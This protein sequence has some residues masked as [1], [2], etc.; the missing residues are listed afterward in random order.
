M[1]EYNLRQLHVMLD[2]IQ[3]FETGKIP[4]GVLIEDLDALLDVME[5]PDNDWKEEFHSNWFTLETY[6]ALALNRNISPFTLDTDGHIPEA[7]D[8]LTSMVH[9]ELKKLNGNIENSCE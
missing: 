7:I 3:R 5:N 8:I 1:N 9:S 6:Y 2:K 4:F